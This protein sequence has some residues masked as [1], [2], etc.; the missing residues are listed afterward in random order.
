MWR[1]HDWGVLTC[2]DRCA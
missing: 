1:Q 2:F